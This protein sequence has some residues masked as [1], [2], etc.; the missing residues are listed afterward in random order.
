MKAIELRKSL[1]VVAL[2][3]LLALIAYLLGAFDQIALERVRFLTSNNQVAEQTNKW[4]GVQI[5]QFPTD[6]M[7]YQ[8]IIT[9]V[10]PDYVIE[11]GTFRGGL[12]LYLASVLEYVNPA[13]KVITVDIEPSMWEETVKDIKT[14][15][16]GKLLERIEFIKGSSIAP[17]TL[18]RIT[19]QVGSGH[20][21]LVL[22]DSVHTKGFVLDELRL[23]SPLVSPGSYV[24]VNDTNLDKTKLVN[25]EEGPLA[26]VK[27]FMANTKEFTIDH[28]RTRFYITCAPSGFLKRNE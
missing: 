2:P 28:S 27:E 1:A 5:L 4:L 19:K 9:E 20:K 17:E 16:A 8:E 11:T 21:V 18:E 15:P 13:G 25:Y 6:M 3:F 22:L 7:V 24:I 23:Y 12:T 10:K 14:R 26:A